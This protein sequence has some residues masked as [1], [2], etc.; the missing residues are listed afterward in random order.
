VILSAPANLTGAGIS[1]NGTLNGGEA[2]TLSAGSSGINFSGAVGSQTPLSSLNVTSSGGT[3]IGGAVKTTGAQIYDAAVTLGNTATLESSGGG[4]IDLT[5]TVNGAQAL[6]AG[7]SGLTTFGGAV[8]GLTP[9][10]SVT[11]EAGGSTAINGGAVTTTGAQSYGG[12]VTLGNNTTLAS[13]AN[14]N[15]AGA[16]ITFSGT[17]DSSGGYAASLNLNAGT[18]G[19]AVF[20]G[21]VGAFHPLGTMNITAG[22]GISFG[23]SVVLG[24]AVNLDSSAGSNGIV[25]GGTL[26]GDGTPNSLTLNAGN[27][28]DVTFTGAVG[29][30]HPLGALDI[31]AGG[32]I[33]FESPVVLGGNTTLDS[34]AGI[35]GISFGL[36]ATLNSNGTPYSLD[37]N[38][39]GSGEA[40][41][42]SAVGGSHPLGTLDIT[43]GGGITFESPVVLGGDAVLT[44]S[45]LAPG[46]GFNAN[47]HNLTLDLSAPLTVSSLLFEDV[48]NFTSNGAGVTTISESF[49]TAGSQTYDNAVTLGANETLTAGGNIT[50]GGT[51]IGGAFNL[52]SQA[53]GSIVFGGAVAVNKLIAEAGGAITADGTISANYNWSD[54]TDLLPTAY[55][56]VLI[57]ARGFTFSNP[58]NLSTNLLLYSGSGG[59]TFDGAVGNV[60]PLT[61]LATWGSTTIAGGF[62]K[63]TGAQTYNSA[64]TLGANTNLSST[65]GSIAF[66]STISGGITSVTLD[67]GNNITFGN[68]VSLGKLLAMAGGDVTIEGTVTAADAGDAVVLVAGNS[69]LNNAGAHAISVPSGGKYLVYSVEPSLDAFGG[70][71]STYQ[72]STSYPTLPGFIGSGFLFSS[73]QLLNILSLSPLPT[74]Q[75]QQSFEANSVFSAF[76]IPLPG[77]ATHGGEI[78]SVIET[79]TDT[80][81]YKRSHKESGTQNQTPDPGAKKI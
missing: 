18:V 66:G 10:T 30:T 41:F 9:L 36:G 20:T 34:S 15:S 3:I 61:S 47:G 5:S 57:G 55:N 48:N 62:V 7:T 24:G 67:A 39:G 81:V 78:S 75:A 49:N 17:L 33:T 51:V 44:S 43:A 59:V 6:T 37:L 71:T 77:A 72:Y 4:A 28:G 26:D 60:T 2:L 1:F 65:G 27:A 42:V 21:G 46:L 69:F 29:G 73:S 38:G 16:N 74:I 54:A 25:F 56:S 63:T 50:F 40:T 13:T 45:T 22:G 58:V 12:A 32:G 68:A 31:V 11:T 35:G 70:L 64:V 80:D 23:S 19:E 53:V 52:T 14:G 8:G 79:P 76:A